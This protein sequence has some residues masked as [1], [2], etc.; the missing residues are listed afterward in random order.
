MKSWIAT[1]LEVIWSKPTRGCEL[2]ETRAGEHRIF[3]VELP[4]PRMLLWCTEEAAKALMESA[5]DGAKLQLV[6]EA[7]AA[8]EAIPE[9]LPCLS[10]HDHS[11]HMS[12]AKTVVKDGRPELEAEREDGYEKTAGKVA[13]TKTSA[14]A[15]TPPKELQK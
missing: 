11:A 13:T 14:A 12:T 6:S 2:L 15:A 5:K 9:G 3:G 1:K 4:G 8:G 10:G 7:K